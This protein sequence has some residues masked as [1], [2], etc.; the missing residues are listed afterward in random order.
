[1]AANPCPDPNIAF[2]SLRHG[3]VITGHPHRPEARVGAQPF[4]FQRRVRGIFHELSMRDPGG[5][6]DAGWKRTVCL[7]ELSRAERF[8]L[9]GSKSAS[10]ISEN[11]AGF[12]FN[13][14]VISSPKAVNARRG[15]VSLLMR[16]HL[17][18]PSNSGRM[19]GKLSAKRSRSMGG[20]AL[21]AASISATVL[22]WLII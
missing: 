6:L 17:A 16:C 4:Q 12:V 13:A 14:A 7:P 10:C 5:F 2:K 22:I 19:E 1:V 21:M 20:N 11:A 15:R 9:D 18:S 8:H 3:A